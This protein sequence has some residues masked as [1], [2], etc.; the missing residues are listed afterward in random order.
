MYK[1]FIFDCG[2]VLIGFSRDHLLDVY[3]GD[4]K[5]DR[6]LVRNNVFPKWHFQDEG[7][8]SK[9]YYEQVKNA[10]PERLWKSAYNIIFHW[11]E[12]VW[13]L[14]GM[15]ELIKELKNKGIK[16][17]LLSNMPDTF[18]YDHDDIEVLKYFDELIFSFPLQFAKPDKR[19]F[20]YTINKCDLTPSDCI[21][22]DDNIDNIKAGKEVGL[23]TYLFDPSHPEKFIDFVNNLE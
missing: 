1:T 16:L 21:F 5:E 11:K 20:E 7:L 3:V 8:S 4:N 17:I 15:W 10:L 22:I 19:I 6:E 2:N 12:E 9:E 18:T 14:P 13:P 23:N